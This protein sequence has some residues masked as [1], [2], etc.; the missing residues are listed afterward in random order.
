M[1]AKNMMAGMGTSP[2]LA[3]TNLAKPKKPTGLGP[4]PLNAPKAMLPSVNAPMPGKPVGRQKALS[5]TPGVNNP[6]VSAAGAVMAG[7]SQMG[8]KMKPTRR[9]M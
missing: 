3:K 7:P 4:S 8:A 6:M 2:A 1:A 5:S 9:K